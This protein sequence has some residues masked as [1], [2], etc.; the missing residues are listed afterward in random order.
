VPVTYHRLKQLFTWNGMKSIV[1]Q[2]VKVMYHSQN[3]FLIPHSNR[4]TDKAC[5]SMPQDILTVLHPFV[6][7]K[8]ETVDAD[9]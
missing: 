3:E 1:H 8:M 4:Q 6:P 2:F 7:P 5:E 9:D